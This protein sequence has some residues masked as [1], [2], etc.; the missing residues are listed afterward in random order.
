MSRE[1]FCQPHEA[2]SVCQ[3]LLLRWQSPGWSSR[4]VWG[5]AQGW[6]SGLRCRSPPSHHT[7]WPPSSGAPGSVGP[8]LG[9]NAMTLWPY[10][11]PRDLFPPHL[12]L[13]ILIFFQDPGQGSL[14]ECWLSCVCRK[15][16]IRGA[17][18][19]TCCVSPSRWLRRQG[20]VSA[21][22]ASHL[23]EEKRWEIWRTEGNC[24]HAKNP[25]L[26]SITDM[27]FCSYFMK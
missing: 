6:S 19:S 3:A 13:E 22:Q 25:L 15:V 20:A 4:L 23:S 17:L 1:S 7:V 2:A 18:R 14:G 27:K 11:V 26:D 9:I 12:L 24:R 8:Y 10:S 5:G 21:I 16:K